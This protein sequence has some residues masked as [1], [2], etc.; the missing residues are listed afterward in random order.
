[1]ESDW[2]LTRPYL[3]PAQSVNV[4]SVTLTSAEPQ[5]FIIGLL[6]PT[7]GDVNVNPLMI[8]TA[9]FGVS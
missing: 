3:P 8:I 6:D 2:N 5:T 9:V 7:S 1:M 4:Q